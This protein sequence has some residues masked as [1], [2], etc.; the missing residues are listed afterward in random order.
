MNFA[1]KKKEN[2]K[3]CQNPQFHIGLKDKFAKT[4]LHMKIVVRRTDKPQKT[5]KGAIPETLSFVVCKAEC[6]EDSQPLRK[7]GGGP[8]QNALGELIPAKES[9]LRR[10]QFKDEHMSNQVGRDTGKTI[11]RRT[12]V[13]KDGFVVFT[14]GHPKTEACVYF[15]HLPRSWLS[16]GLIIV[17]SLSAVG[18][19]GNFVVEVFSSETLDVTQIPEQFMKSVAGEF[20]PNLSGGSHVCE[21]WK[22]NPRMI[23]KLL[24]R[25]MQRIPVKLRITI[26][27]H[28]DSWGPACRSDAVGNMIGFYVFKTENGAME[29]VQEVP[30]VP[31]KEV[32]TDPSFALEPLGDTEDYI[33]MPAT[34]SEGKLGSFVV[35]VAC[36]CEVSLTRGDAK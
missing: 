8:R 9:S 24:S 21:N 22:K 2:P 10:K 7:K 3:W 31:D 18:A 14:T 4:D 30:L 33:V 16:N 13:P 26:S 12:S 1:D 36:D 27:R 35:S 11:L 6:L 17:P 34:F 29:L 19:K 25:D 5:A 28:G 23:L 15:P 20:T 32:S